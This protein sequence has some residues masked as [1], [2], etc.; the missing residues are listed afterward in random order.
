VSCGICAGSCPT[1]TPFRRRGGLTPGIQLVDRTVQDLKDSMFA[2]AEKLE[3]NDRV[4]LFAC[5]HGG[6]A[7][8]DAESAAGVVAIPCV[9]ALPPS[10]I[11]YALSRNLADGVMIGGCR[12]GD[13]YNRFGRDWLLARVERSR[14]PYLGK[15]VPRE[16]LALSWASP[17]DDDAVRA[18]LSAFQAKLRELPANPPAGTRSA[19]TVS[20][21]QAIGTEAAAD[22]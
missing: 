14:D 5:D 7:R 9:A 3:G 12:K 4:L 2:A 22:D 6:A 17:I 15:R 16:R 11:D 21:S 8:C 18:D 1:S 19:N 20:A 10:F 13:C